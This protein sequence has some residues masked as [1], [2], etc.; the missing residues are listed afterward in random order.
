M[1]AMRRD[2]EG[3][4]SPGLWLAVYRIVARIMRLDLALTMGRASRVLGVDGLLARRV[5]RN[6]EHIGLVGRLLPYAV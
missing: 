6:G 3:W 5:E 1:T 2:E 4:R